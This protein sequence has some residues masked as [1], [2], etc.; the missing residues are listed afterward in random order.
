MSRIKDL[1]MKLTE[2]EI[3]NILAKYGAFVHTET[4]DALIFPT[5]CHNVDGGSP[6]LYYYKED[7]IFRCYTE[8]NGMF[9]I[10]DL[11]GKMH[12]L[13]GETITLNHAIDLT[14]VQR[15][16][17]QVDS[18]VL[19]DLEYLKKLSSINNKVVNENT[20]RI[21]DNNILNSFMYNEVGVQPWIEEGISELALNRFNIK[22]DSTKNAIIIPNLD[23]QGNLIGIRGRFFGE[24]APAK[25]MP[26]KYNGEILSHP[27]GKFLYGYYENKHVIREKGLAIIFEGEKSV[28]KMETLYPQSNIALATAGKK[29]TLDQLNALLKLN[30]N[31][32]IL[33][34][35]KDYKTP[36]ERKEK[37]VEYD[38]IVQ[39]LKPYFSVSIIVDFTNKLQYKDS[40]IDQGKDVFD[41]LVRNRVKR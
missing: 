20:V 27:T 40:P 26:I 23:H 41:E 39:I 2:E 22:Y 18:Q 32:V 6:K 28:L 5:V 13:R 14:G 34:Y 16:I 9:D 19:E 21:L 12:K 36:E 24:N 25:Y 11:L 37:L 30:L 17:G 10:F 38:K 7:K 4:E 15:D 1:R 8:C 35:D 33:A 29:I 31:E 3:K